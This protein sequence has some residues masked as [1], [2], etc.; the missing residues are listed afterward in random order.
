[1]PLLAARFPL[2]GTPNP[3]PLAP[4]GA[5]AANEL[6]TGYAWEILRGDEP[7]ALLRRVAQGDSGLFRSVAES[8]RLRE[9]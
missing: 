3:H 5:L 9:Q 6:A 8:D 1:M 4:P 2:P 7:L